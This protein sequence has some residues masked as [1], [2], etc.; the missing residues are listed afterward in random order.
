MQ[1]GG[2][3]SAK[4]FVSFLIFRIIDKSFKNF[5]LRN[6][7]FFLKRSVLFDF[8]ASPTSDNS[9]LSPL[10]TFKLKKSSNNKTSAKAEARKVKKNG[11]P[12][13]MHFLCS[14]LSLNA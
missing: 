4:D 6:L 14:C 5:R 7:K 3:F 12:F 9:V 11:N 8:S 2:G 1:R 13:R 10:L